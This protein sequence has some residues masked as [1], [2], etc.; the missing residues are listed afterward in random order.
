MLSL[1]ALCVDLC[2]CGS[3]FSLAT[4]VWEL[5]WTD[6]V[7]KATLHLPY[8]TIAIGCWAPGKHYTLLRGWE[9]AAWDVVG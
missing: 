8:A 6:E 1:R 4:G 3:T 9:N 5:H 2:K 7:G